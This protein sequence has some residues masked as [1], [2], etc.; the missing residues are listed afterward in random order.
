[1][2]FSKIFFEMAEMDQFSLIGNIYDVLILVLMANA[3][4][5]NRL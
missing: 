3:N 2:T 5:L 1:M 4:S